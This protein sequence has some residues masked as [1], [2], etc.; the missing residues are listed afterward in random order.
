MAEPILDPK[1]RK[2]DGA[3]GGLVKE[4]S[5]ATFLAD[6]IDGSRDVP[7]IVDFWAP[8]CGPCRQLGPILEKT[9]TA[10]SGK[11]RLVKINVDEN[12]DIA[13]QLRIQSIPAVIAFH[14]GRPVDA[15]AGA[16][17][18]SQVKQFVDRL[19]AA[20]PGAQDAPDPMVAQ[21]LDQ[22]KARLA[23]GDARTAAALYS[24]VATHDPD[25]LEAKAGLARAHI[26]LGDLANAKQ[27][28]DGLGDDD[29]KNAEVAG[30]L[31]ALGLA[32]KGAGAGDAASLRAKLAA[33]PADHQARFDLSLALFGAGEREAA[34]DALIE[35][36]KKSREW[37][38][39]AA[40][41]QL[42]EFFE[43]MG[44]TDPVTLA[45]R[46]KL[47]SVLFS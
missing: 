1:A 13:Q 32:E 23:A 42:L 14:G 15:F 39:Q 43:A 25:N 41:K 11:V 2:A 34:V 8:W 9:V 27:A 45:G 31:T 3:P 30:A 36:I 16:L 4:G 10:A 12:P 20:S 5:T 37:N 38:E 7:V 21:A 35:I 44:P 28:L 6:V 29:R 24:R 47:S 18:E 26:A 22:A 19:A 40:R 33:D 46:R 17:P